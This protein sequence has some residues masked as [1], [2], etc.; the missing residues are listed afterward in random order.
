MSK[1]NQTDI[2][3]NRS[4][5]TGSNGGF[6]VSA[7]LLVALLLFPTQPA[8]SA[9]S[10]IVTET[11]EIFEYDLHEPEAPAEP[12]SAAYGQ[13]GPF[14]VIA[15]DTVEMTGTVDS[16]TPALFRQMMRHF[17][18]IKR[19]EMLDCDGSVDEEANL[20]LARMIRRYQHQ[21]TGWRLGPV[22]CCRTVSFRRPADSTS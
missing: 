19:I 2:S 17:P 21:R 16:Y 11:V 13:Y 12:A 22:R 14:R 1:S 6:L 18:G 15:A 4:D 9:S 20:R 7:F 8:I 10:Y 3:Q 5:S